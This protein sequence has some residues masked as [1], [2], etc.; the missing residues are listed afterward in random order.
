LYVDGAARH[1]PGPA[2]AGICLLKG[3]EIFIKRG[4]FLGVCTNNQA[5]YL[6]LVIGL[7]IGLPEVGNEHLRII[8]DSQLLINQINGVYRV[9]NPELKILHNLV[10]L[11]LDKK[12]YDAIH[13]LRTH[14]QIADKM[15][16]LGIDEKIE[17]PIV[18]KKKLHNH[19]IEI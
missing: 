7:I 17:I 15:A 3:N 1:N 5:E 4:F 8:S 6:A 12:S 16:N 11:L 9:K 14:N 2:G 10:E 18:I 19:G 13:V